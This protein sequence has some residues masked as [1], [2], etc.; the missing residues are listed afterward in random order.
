[1]RPKE[2]CR[3]PTQTDFTNGA[4]LFSAAFSINWTRSKSFF[5]FCLVWVTRRLMWTM[6]VAG[7]VRGHNYVVCV[8]LVERLTLHLIY[9]YILDSQHSLVLQW[10]RSR[11]TIVRVLENSKPFYILGTRDWVCVCVS[12]CMP[13]SVRTL[14]LSVSRFCSICQPH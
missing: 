11:D 14:H 6:P 7:M 13:V 4:H 1:M 10:G 3:L 9:E 12:M 5:L 8:S 2:S